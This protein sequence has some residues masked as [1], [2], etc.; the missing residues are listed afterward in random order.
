VPTPPRSFTRT[1]DVLTFSSLWVAAAAAAL[2]VACS[3]AMGIA[4][5]GAAVGLAFAG[6]L[7]VYNVDRLR[8]LDAD[9]ATAPDRSA[10][11]AKHGGNLALVT[12]A[13]A[14]GSLVFALAGGTRVWAVLVP[15]LGLGL[16]H[17]RIKHLVFGKSAYITAAWVG[18]VAGVPALIDPAATQVAWTVAIT[19]AAL[20]ANAMASSVRDLEVAAAR[21]GPRRA[22]Y[23]ARAFALLGVSVAAAAPAPARSLMAVPAATLFALL[24]FRPGER[25]GLRVVDGA[26]LA[27]A[28]V[29]GGVA[30]L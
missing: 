10:F 1:L 13:A 25:Y 29:A 26:L 12:V 24:L 3:L 4:V 5:A 2:T 9:R 17:R 18:V 22:L 28:V 6:T 27:G 11:V 21:F 8:D 20:F 14:V 19:A 23:A 30:S 7:V 16:L 15:I